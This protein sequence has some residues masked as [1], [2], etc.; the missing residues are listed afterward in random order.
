MAG[1]ETS[2]DT[3]WWVFTLPALLPIAA[4]PLL[5]VL[6]LGVALLAATLI[7][8][9]ASSGGPAW[10]HHR[11][12]IGKG[13]I[14][15]IRGFPILGSLLSLGGL[16][17]RTLAALS[18]LHK[19]SAASKLMSFSLGSTPAVVSSDPATAREL[20]SHPLLSDRP[21]KLSARELFFSRAIGFAP[22]GTYWR[23]LRRLASSHLF[24]PRRLAFHSAA[25]AADA[26]TLLRAVAAEQ[27]LK[28]AVLLRR[29]L[30]FAALNNITGTTFGV[31]YED[32]SHPEARELQEMVRGLRPPRILQ[33]L[34]QPPVALLP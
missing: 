2:K 24:S 15:G 4:D 1:M 32:S 12:R 34:R 29:H 22:S 23:F 31:R 11:S 10:P 20:L 28:G 14:P 17:H 5:V 21:V 27:S 30:Q 3:N 16:P 33:H 25:R 13:P 19:N 26:S 6:S 8:W 18:R 7:A 9:A